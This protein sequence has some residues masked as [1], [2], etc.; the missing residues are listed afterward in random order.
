MS[1]SKD[2]MS[3]RP[4]RKCLILAHG[5]S[6]LAHS[7]SVQITD[8][9]YMYNLKLQIL[10]YVDLPLI[11]LLIVGIVAIFCNFLCEKMG[12]SCQPNKC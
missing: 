1:C 2:F 6:R 7:C 9:F 4:T 11:P 8:Y 3:G 10:Y 12:N 5:I